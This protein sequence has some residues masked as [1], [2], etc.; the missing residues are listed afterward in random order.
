MLAYR[1]RF[2][3][4]EAIF[5]H[6]SYMDI[7]GQQGSFGSELIPSVWMAISHVNIEALI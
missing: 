2:H 6:D 3:C 7:I 5:T 1:T 4:F